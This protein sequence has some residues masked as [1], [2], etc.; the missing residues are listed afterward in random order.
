MY[1]VSCRMSSSKSSP[2]PSALVIQFTLFISFSF[3]DREDRAMWESFSAGLDRNVHFH[4]LFVTSVSCYKAHHACHSLFHYDRGHCSQLPSPSPAAL[5][6]ES[7]SSASSPP[8]PRRSSSPPHPVSPPSG[9]SPSKPR[10]CVA[11]RPSSCRPR[12]NLP[13]G[14]GR[15]SF[16]PCPDGRSG[17]DRG[18]IECYQRSIGMGLRLGVDTRWPR[19]ASR[20]GTNEG[21]PMSATLSR[22]L[23][24]QYCL[25]GGLT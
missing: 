19:I 22:S 25:F 9:S 15:N 14:F 2:S 11:H 10:P 6:S 12:N 16:R 20:Y 18:G 13:S 23:N 1:S 24:F 7:T 8:W 5:T 3:E 4:L 21:F 17:G